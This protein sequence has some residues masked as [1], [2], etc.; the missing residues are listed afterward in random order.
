MAKKDIE[1]HQIKSGQVLNPKGRPP[2]FYTQ[3]IK[4]VKEDYLEIEGTTPTNAE[5]KEWAKLLLICPRKKLLDVAKDD[6]AHIFL[7][8]AAKELASGN[9][10]SLMELV[11][12]A[13]GKPA[14]QQVE[15][16]SLD[17]TL[18]NV[19][20]IIIEHTNK[21]QTTAPDDYK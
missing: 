16:S 4:Q 9:F 19:K 13:Y 18:Q 15:V 21:D 1:K 17:Q 14:Q 8:S 2:R 11:Y 5:I 12:F 7:A 3:F 6:S 20:R 10:K